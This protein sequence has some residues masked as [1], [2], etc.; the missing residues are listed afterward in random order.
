MVAEWRRQA[1][2]N[3]DNDTDSRLGRREPAGCSNSAMRLRCSLSSSGTSPS[4]FCGGGQKGRTRPGYDGHVHNGPSTS[5]S[6]ASSASARTSSH[7]AA[8]TDAPTLRTRPQPIGTHIITKERYCC[9]RGATP[10]PTHLLV[11]APTAVRNTGP[12]RKSDVVAHTT[13]RA[14][15]P[16]PSALP[17][18]SYTH[19]AFCL[20]HDLTRRSHHPQW[21]RS[22]RA[23]PFSSPGFQPV[24]PFSLPACSALRR[25]RIP[26]STHAPAALRHA[27]ARAH[28]HARARTTD[29]ER[30]DVRPAGVADWKT[31]RGGGT[32]RALT[33]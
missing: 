9:A 30:R 24:R 32:E 11:H 18:P 33:A 16:L 4:A 8:S 3:D 12:S 28:T 23:A 27:C 22:T 25:V 5:P 21:S 6:A 1:E 20:M 14:P 31:A 19:G 29:D 26:A 13:P 15:L 17:A 2:D 10:T 7:T